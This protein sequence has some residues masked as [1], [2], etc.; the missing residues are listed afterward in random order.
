MS[1]STSLLGGP[2]PTK[3]DVH[4]VLKGPL[5]CRSRLMLTCIRIDAH[6]AD[7]TTKTEGALGLKDGSI[8]N[9]LLCCLLCQ[10]SLVP[11]ELEGSRQGKVRGCCCTW[12]MYCLGLSV[13]VVVPRCSTTVGRLS[14]LRQPD[15]TNQ[16]F[17]SGEY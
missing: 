13:A 7:G 2:P 8:V 16:L 14:M 4:D 3:T 11:V 12:V 6:A 17:C 9:C 5:P 1:P 15:R 10:G